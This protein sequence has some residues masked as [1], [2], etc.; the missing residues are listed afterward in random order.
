MMITTATIA[1]TALYFIVRIWHSGAGTSPPE[2]R[3]QLYAKGETDAVPAA[4]MTVDDLTDGRAL[5]DLSP[6]RSRS[7]FPCRHASRA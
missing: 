2:P 1:V 6:S 3:G 4:P 7:K 5:V